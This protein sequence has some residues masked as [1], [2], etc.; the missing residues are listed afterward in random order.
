METLEGADHE[1]NAVPLA[2]RDQRA[3]VTLKCPETR[4][5]LTACI[6]LHLRIN[7]SVLSATSITNGLLNII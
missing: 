2:V 5:R 3:K 7:A 4:C 6:G 1:A